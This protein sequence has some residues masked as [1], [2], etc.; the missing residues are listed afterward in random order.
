MARAAFITDRLL[1]RFGLSGKAFIPMLM[2]FG[3]SVPAVM[4]ARTMENDKD[5]RMTILLVP[6]MSCSAKLPVYALI[7]AAFFGTWAGLAVFSLYLLGMAAAVASGFIFRRTIFAGEPAPFVMELP[8]Y[9]L[10]TVNNTLIHV[11]DRVK[12]FLVRAGTLIFFMSVVLWVLRN[13]NGQLQMAQSGADSLLARFGMLVA[14]VFKPQGFPMWQ[15]SVAL[16]TGLI[17]KE[18]VVASLSMLYGFSLT[19][20][21][22]AVQS[23]MTGFTPLAAFSYLVFILLYIPCVAAVSTIYRETNSLRWT[24]F[25]AAWQLVAAYV[26][27]MVVYQAGRLLGLG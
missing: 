8:V 10:P 24:V 20:G 13:F 23:A 2:G 4:G 21:G 5:R 26:V 1:R 12:G 16:L 19:A 6:F 3:C 27:S 17:A 11:W 15:A 22:V 9:R 7:A 18:A 25:S 14:P